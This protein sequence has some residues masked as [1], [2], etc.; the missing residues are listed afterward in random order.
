MKDLV[1]LQ[2]FEVTFFCDRI[3]IFLFDIS[4]L[5]FLARKGEVDAVMTEDGD[6]V[7][8]CAPVILFKTK[9]V[10]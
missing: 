8:F 5:A 2:T 7:S 1:P 3:L 6:L 4:Q 9:Q 10:C